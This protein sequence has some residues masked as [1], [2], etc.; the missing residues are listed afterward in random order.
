MDDS[1]WVATSQAHGAQ[2][3]LL[4]AQ[5]SRVDGAWVGAV[6]PCVRAL[7]TPRQP[8]SIP[9]VMHDAMLPRQGPALQAMPPSL[10]A[11]TVTRI[12]CPWIP[13]KCVVSCDKLFLSLC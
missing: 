7:G 10:P 1:P 5:G 11:W 13:S 8:C 12:M 4:S 9:L 2:Q 3:G 6:V